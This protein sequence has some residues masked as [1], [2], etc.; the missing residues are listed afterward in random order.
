MQDSKAEVEKIDAAKKGQ[1][2]DDAKLKDY[3]VCIAKRIGFV[4]AAGVPQHSVLKAK[5]GGFFDDQALADKLDAECTEQKSSPQET[6]THMIK[7]FF[8]KNPNTAVI[9]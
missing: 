4:D 9:I 5:I 2:A 8:E 6:V 1:F 7:C 3:F